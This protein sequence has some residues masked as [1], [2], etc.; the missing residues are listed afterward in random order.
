MS[1]RWLLSIIE[2][3]AVWKLEWHSPKKCRVGISLLESS[4]HTLRNNMIC[5][6]N[7]HKRKWTNLNFSYQWLSMKLPS[8]PTIFTRSFS[9]S[10]RDPITMSVFRILLMCFRILTKLNAHLLRRKPLEVEAR[11]RLQL[12]WLNNCFKGAIIVFILG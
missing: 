5:S 2:E 9:S 4:Y 6:D 11:M 12:M 1:F 3:Q 8:G 7:S 10:S